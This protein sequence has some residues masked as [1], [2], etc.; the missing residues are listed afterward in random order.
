VKVGHTEDKFFSLKKAEK[1]L[2]QAKAR[3]NKVHQNYVV[4][5]EFW[6]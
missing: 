6:N 2:K 4:I 3:K 5:I 1:K